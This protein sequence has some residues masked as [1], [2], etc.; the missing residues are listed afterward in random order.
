MGRRTRLAPLGQGEVPGQIKF[1]L[2][3]CGQPVSY[4]A[5]EFFAEV[6]PC[7]GKRASPGLVHSVLGG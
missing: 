2:S 4:E 1:Q 6:L 3:G 7:E 5:V